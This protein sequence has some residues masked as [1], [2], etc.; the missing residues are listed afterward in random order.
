M[1]PEMILFAKR[2]I[3]LLRVFSLWVYF[4]PLRWRPA[5]IFRLG[6]WLSP[7]EFQGKMMRRA[8]CL[9]TPESEVGQTWCKWLDS[10]LQFV[11]DFLTYD[12]LNADW[13]KTAVFVTNP[14]LTDELRRSGGLLLTYHTHHQNTLCCALGLEGIKISA[15]AA[16]PEDS[17]LFPH[18]G[19]WAK[20]VNSD[21][22]KHFGGGGYIFTDNLRLLLRTTRQRLSDHET[23][24][25]LCDFHQPKAGN[26]VGARLFDRLISPPTGAI[27]IALKHGAPIF[28][29]MFA[30]K[31]G[32]LTLELIRLDESGGVDSIL[33]GYF[34]FL[35][36]GIRSN[37]ACWQG[38]E[39]FEDLPI[40]EQAKL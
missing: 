14:A 15:I 3:R 5:F 31:N 38:W 11:L 16:L 13:L 27:E 22:A 35:E 37:P 20:R 10:H 25:C 23:V 29:A 7:F 12:A 8:I 2:Y 17:P 26:T 4:A 21:S 9:V 18:I 24:V 28:A 30:P 36:T 33:A 40:A 6:R 32:K 1:S 34:S 39:W 19:R